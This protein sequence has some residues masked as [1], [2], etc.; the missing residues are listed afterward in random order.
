MQKNNYLL[1]ILLFSLAVFTTMMAG[2]ELV[3]GRQIFATTDDPRVRLFLSDIL[4]GAQFSFAFL[5]FLTV[6]EF[7]HYLT[8]RYHRVSCSLP[9]YIPI[10]IPYLTPINIGSFGAVIRLREIPDSLRKFFDIGIAGPLAGFVV[11]VGLLIYGFATL[12][13]MEEYVYEIHESYAI[14]FG[15]VPDQAQLLESPNY[16]MVL[17]VGTNL[18]FEF[19]K[20]VVPGDP[21]RV[22]PPHEMMH[23]PFLF[24]GFLALF[25]TALNLL[26]IGQLD[27]GHV[28]YGLFG[29][30]VAGIISRITVVILVFMGGTGIMGWGYDPAID[31]SLGNYLLFKL[32]G[33]LIYGGF[34]YLVYRKITGSRSFGSLLLLI[35]VTMSL[36]GLFMALMPGTEANGLWLLYS[37]LAVRVL[38][39]DHPPA[40]VEAPLSRRQVVLGWVAIAIFVLCF[41]P[42]PLKL[43]I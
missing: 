33:W 2:A 40:L 35:A 27:G 15:G 10:F 14:E 34:L 6:H 5:L 23:Y 31:S 8:A 37:F 16:S 36:Q 28:T 26:P 4:L 43:T 39:I 30:R 19:L 29:R 18:L 3:S 32:L 24:A 7:G 25:F 17:S 21:D 9:Y 20:E 42:E 12:P 1:H 22:P 13:P 38:G 41:T 11:S